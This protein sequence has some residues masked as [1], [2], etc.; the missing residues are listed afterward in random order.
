MLSFHPV[1]IHGTVNFK[2]A[3]RVSWHGVERFGNKVNI[4]MNNIFEERQLI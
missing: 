3:M 1:Y 4:F 2:E